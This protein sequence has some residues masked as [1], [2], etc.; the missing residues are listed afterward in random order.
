[1]ATNRK[2]RRAS[3]P[4]EDEVPRRKKRTTS[5][6]SRSSSRESSRSEPITIDFTKDESE[7]G[8]RRFPEGDYHV[9]YTGFK[10]GRSKEKDTPYVR[11]MFKILDGKYKGETVSDFLYLSP[12]ALWRIRT[13]LEAI[14]VAVPKKKVNINFKK[15]VGKELGI[16]LVDDEYE[17][18]VRSRVGDCLDLDTFRG[19]D[20]DDE[21]FDE[22]DEDTDDDEGDEDEDED[23][24]EE[25][26]DDDMEDMDVDDDL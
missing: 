11:V 12:K 17:G 24:D 13:F 8:R 26:E 20:E 16:T 7:G 25:D 3:E 15:Y 21:D 19:A 2:K 4:D 23:E 5:G 9:K 6:S 14:G 10:T 18:R 22:D 1:M